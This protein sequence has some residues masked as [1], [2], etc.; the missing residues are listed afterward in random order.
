[1]PCHA[2]YESRKK[3]QTF[4][5]RCHQNTTLT[6]L[7]PVVKH[8]IMC[9]NHILNHHPTHLTLLA[10]Y[11][12]FGPCHP[13]RQMQLELKQYPLRQVP[14]SH[15]DPLDGSKPDKI[16]LGLVHP[17]LLNT[18]NNITYSSSSLS[19]DQQ[20]L[21]DVV[22]VVVVLVLVQQLELRRRHLPDEADMIVRIRCCCCLR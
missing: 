22:F 9:L 3:Y 6:T 11:W 12:Q 5:S 17:T 14:G 1:M 13:S 2:L 16:E 20:L 4:L 18:I 7:Y 19:S 8:S 10:Q 21:D 15:V